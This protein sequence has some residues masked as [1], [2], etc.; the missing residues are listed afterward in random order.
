MPKKLM[1]FSFQVDS[2]ESTQET[3]INNIPGWFSY[4][5]TL[6]DSLFEVAYFIGITEDATSPEGHFYTLGYNT[7]VQFPYTVRATCILVEKGFYSEAIILIRNLYET[8]FQLRYFHKH[9]NKLITHWKKEKPKIPIKTMFEEIAPNFYDKVYGN[10]FSE[11][12]HSG[13]SSSMF[14]TKYQ[15]PE[16]GETTMGSKYNEDGC[17]YSLNKIVVVLFGL[18][19]YV[20][21]LFPQYPSLVSNTTETKRKE[22]LAGLESI[23]KAHLASKPEAQEFYDLVYSLIYI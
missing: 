2:E 7:L 12:A 21:I 16:I 20:P 19:N 22:S 18:L 1:N 3:T 10:E 9:Q 8:F 17:T 13:L 6:L 15:S 23:M 11:F 4:Y 14:R 5:P